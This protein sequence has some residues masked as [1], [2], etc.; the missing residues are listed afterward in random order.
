MDKTKL[1]WRLSKSKECNYEPNVEEGLTRLKNRIQA[2][3][4][5][6]EHAQPQ[7]R[8]LHIWKY[9]AAA[10]ILLVFGLYL[11]KSNSSS[12][13]PMLSVQT[14]EAEKS[15]VTL[16]DGT[17]VWL[18]EDSKLSYP[19]QFGDSR[20][21]KLEGEA[22]FDVAKDADHPFI[23][24]MNDAQIMVL[25]TSFNVRS[26]LDEKETT[27]A[28]RSGKVR[29]TPNGSKQKWDLVA[30]DKVVYD[31]ENK[32]FNRA[33]DK[34]ENDWSWHSNQ[35]Q[36]HNSLLKNVIPAIERHYNIKIQLNNPDLYTCRTYT[37]SFKDL[38]E[39]EVLE[40]LKIAFDLRIKKTAQNA[41]LL[42]GGICK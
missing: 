13:A 16:T 41:Y 6:S 9:A 18:N 38:R 14:I 40:A 42:F 10:A 23:I 5:K 28:V 32:R 7:V 39:D 30:H 35:L 19:D 31:I 12:T 27:V 25:G 22:F 4:D 20:R 34:S 33:N 36:F 37:S 2:D 1:L 29:F 21:V 15:Q 8:R 17:Q 3:L 24:E 26:Y 11:N